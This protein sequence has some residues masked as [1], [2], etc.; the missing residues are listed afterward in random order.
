MRYLIAIVL[1]W[2]ALFMIGKTFQGL[3]CLF[4]QFTMI[5][6]LPAAI[7]AVLAVQNH[8]ADKRTEQLIRAIQSK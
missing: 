5:G 7:W 1:P 8:N 4:L 3:V 6:W 2:L